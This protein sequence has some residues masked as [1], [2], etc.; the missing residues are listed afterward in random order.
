MHLNSEIHNALFKLPLKGT[1]SQILQNST[2]RLTLK[3]NM[4][5]DSLK[6]SLSPTGYMI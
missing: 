6:P 1:S 4:Q 2:K 5:L 3:E